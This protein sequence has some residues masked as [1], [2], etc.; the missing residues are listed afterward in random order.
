MAP[1]R[2]WCQGQRD[3]IVRQRRCACEAARQ[4]GGF[5]AQ[6]I[7]QQQ[8]GLVRKIIRRDGHDRRRLVTCARRCSLQQVADSLENVPCGAHAYSL[9]VTD[10]PD[11]VRGRAA[12]FYAGSVWGLPSLTANALM[13]AKRRQVRAGQRCLYWKATCPRASSQALSSTHA[14][15]TGNGSAARP[16]G[17]T[18]RGGKARSR[19]RRCT[20]GC[21]ART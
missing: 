4:H 16:L 12:S 17:R 6:V 7:A 8:P 21:R 20:E 2:A 9:K 15:R 14:P 3:A 1:R 10:A 19:S 18:V 5:V 13:P 11:V